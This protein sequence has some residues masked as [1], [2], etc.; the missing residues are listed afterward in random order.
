MFKMHV[1]NTILTATA[2][3]SAGVAADFLVITDYPQALQTLSPEQVH[4]H[5]FSIVLLIQKLT[6][7]QGEAWLS[8][9]LPALQSEFVSLATDPSYLAQATAVIPALREFAATATVRALISPTQ[10]HHPCLISP[11]PQSPQP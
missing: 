2:A 7:P 6:Y 3:L 5:I 1:K 4:T 10:F 9:N 8:S 11:R